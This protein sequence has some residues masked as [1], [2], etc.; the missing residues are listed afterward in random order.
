MIFLVN[1]EN[2]S[3]FAA[4]LAAMHRQRKIVFVDRAGW[5]VPVSGDQEIDRYDR[6]DTLYLLAKDAPCGP[7]LASVRLLPTQ[8]PHLM[9]ELFPL[10]CLAAIPRGPT[11][12][13]ASRMCVAPGLRAERRAHA[14]VWEMVCGVL[15]T[16]LLY[17]IDQ[18]VFAVNR[19]LLRL[20]LHCGWEVRP[21][22]PRLGAGEQEVAAA[23]ATV[24]A[25]GLR[26]V[27]QRHGIS[28][29]ATRLHARLCLPAAPSAAGSI[30]TP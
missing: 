3:Q 10:A 25:A 30:A 17:G 14:L 22:G 26:A 19:A 13:E 15:E 5:N 11:V 2:R 24:T 7:I 6:D 21:L 18:V 20:V 28:I 9:S 29:P 23:A 27:R 1:A 8:R 4:D 16:A 12:W